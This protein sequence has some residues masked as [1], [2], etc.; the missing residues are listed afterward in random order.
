MD[1]KETAKQIV[2]LLETFDYKTSMWKDKLLIK[3]SP[4]NE[5][6]RLYGAGLGTEKRIW[7][8]DGDKWYPFEATDHNAE[9]VAP[10]VLQRL[11]TIKAGL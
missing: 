3:S 1:T 9:Y 6:C 5:I 8:F 4:H 10:S 2:E 7:L 11:K